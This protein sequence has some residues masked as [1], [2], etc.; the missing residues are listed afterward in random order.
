MTKIFISHASEDK[1][2]VEKFLTLI[3]NLGLNIQTKEILCSSTSGTGIS[4]GENWKDFIKNNLKNAEVVIMV[5]TPN[6]KKSEMC[7][8][9]AGA[10]WALSKEI[11]PLIIEPINYDNVGVIFADKQIAKITESE[12]L[13]RLKD[14][15]K[16]ILEIESEEPSDRWTQLKQ[17]FISFLT[18]HLKKNPFKD[19]CLKKKCPIL[20]IGSGILLGLVLGLLLFFL[21]L[22]P[23]LHKP[24]DVKTNG[25]PPAFNPLGTGKQVVTSKKVEINETF[26][27]SP[28]EVARY[29][30]YFIDH[31]DFIWPQKEISSG[32]VKGGYFIPGDF[33]GGKLVLALVSK[34]TIEDF[35]TGGKVKKTQE[36][37]IIKIIYEKEISIKK[38]DGGDYEKK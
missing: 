11:I 12:S 34:D 1:P 20:L 37:K 17:E 6:F 2:I 29:W 25:K 9:E 8:N 38:R 19:K 30:L 16:K 22:G 21:F 23:V 24:D 27:Y 31:D 33:K 13:D 28:G 36:F 7:Q 4:P 18:K 35:F 3:L 26:E 5:I 15:L 32:E 14:K 10:A